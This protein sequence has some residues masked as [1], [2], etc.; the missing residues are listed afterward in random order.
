MKKIVASVSCFALAI[1]LSQ[2]QQLVVLKN[3]DRIAGKIVSVTN[4]VVNFATKT[5]GTKGYKTNEISLIYFD[6][7]LVPKAQLSNSKLPSG[8]VTADVPGR[9]ITKTPDM[10]ILTQDKGIVVVNIIVDKY[11]RVKK[12]EPGGEGTN[13]TSGYLLTKAKQAAE[14]TIFDTDPTYPLET[15]GTITVVF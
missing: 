13:T 4:D 6:E 10:K 14:A 15:K 8:T 5:D 1:T 3:G 7:N 9:K 2:A 11:G 12:A